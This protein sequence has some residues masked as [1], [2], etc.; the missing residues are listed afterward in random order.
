MSR[1]GVQQ[2]A[3]RRT[4]RWGILGPGEVAH[5]FARDLNR[6]V[7]SECVAVGSRD[8]DRARG[9]AA[10]HGIPL[11]VGSYAELV[12]ID[13]V[14]VVYVATPH[15]HHY[16]HALLALSA[17][18]H[19]L[20]EKPL[21]MTAEEGRRLAAFAQESQLF[22]M[23]GLWTAFNPLVLRAR[24]MLAS[25]TLGAI[26]SITAT[27]G[28]MGVPRHSRVL[29]P[30]L[31]ASFA[32]ECLIYPLSVG[33]LLHPDSES[34]SVI[35]AACVRDAA[36]AVETGISAILRHAGGPMMAFHGGFAP[37][38][39][40]RGLSALHVIGEN[41]WL[42]LTDTL[43]NPSLLR[44]AV[45]ELASEVRCESGGL[46]REI[47]AV[48]DALRSGLEVSPILPPSHSVQTLGLIE[49]IR[50]HAR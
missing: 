30:N 6:V 25:R 29:D 9:F 8:P 5:R 18:R 38:S 3:V 50:A 46:E 43:F 48:A 2:N 36:D 34:P 21:A 11:A 27:I 33:L 1:V 17:G 35:S 45:G 28:A 12:A 40:G 32:H 24:D 22:L 20:V 26:A 41:G 31:G 4:V 37:G 49:A 39:A 16:E 44:Y 19:V 23:E 14:D 7:D 15:N 10:R 42:E 47:E 13:D